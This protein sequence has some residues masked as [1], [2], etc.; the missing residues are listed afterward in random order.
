MTYVAETLIL[1][2]ELDHKLKVSQRTME[3]ATLGVC[4]R[5]ELRNKLIRKRTK[6]IGISRRISKL[7]MGWLFSSEHQWLLE[8]KS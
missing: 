2:E 1:T 5:D 6:V 8:Q 3:R 7:V 4:L